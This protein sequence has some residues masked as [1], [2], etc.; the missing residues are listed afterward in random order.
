MGSGQRSQEPG[1]FGNLKTVVIVAAGH[2]AATGTEW[3]ETWGDPNILQSAG[4]PSQQGM[5][6]FNLSVVLLLTN[7]GKG[8]STL[9]FFCLLYILKQNFYWSIVDLQC[10]ARM[11]MY[12]YHLPFP[13][14]KFLQSSLCILQ[15]KYIIILI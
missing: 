12:S 14:I 2:R 11:D 3:V 6:W 8:T 10:C 7:V 5:V 15:N 4:R 9:F 13:L 1:A